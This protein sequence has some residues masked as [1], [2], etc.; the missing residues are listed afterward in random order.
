[1]PA[2]QRREADKRA[3]FPVNSPAQKIDRKGT[4]NCCIGSYSADG[5]K[6]GMPMTP[7]R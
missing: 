6:G 7:A 4:L 5:E 1:M 2:A 3:T